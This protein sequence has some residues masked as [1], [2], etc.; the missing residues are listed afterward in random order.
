[1]RRKY[2]L[3]RDGKVVKTI[4]LHTYIAERDDMR[5]KMRTTDAQEIYK[6][7]S[8]TAE[9]VIGDIKENK[10]F[11]AFLTRTLETVK[12]EF[13][14]VCIAHNIKKLYVMANKDLVKNFDLMFMQLFI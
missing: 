10:G 13:N 5:K 9:P 3:R 6:I 12:T 4:K 8:Q 7:R 1:M 14:L 2:V 11:T